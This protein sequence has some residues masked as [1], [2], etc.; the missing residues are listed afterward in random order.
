MAHFPICRRFKL[1]R[2]AP[3][4]DRFRDVCQPVDNSP[5]TLGAVAGT[6]KGVLPT[7]CK[8]ALHEDRELLRIGA[9]S[10]RRTEETTEID[11]STIT[12]PT[13]E[14]VDLKAQLVRQ[15]EFY[16]RANYVSF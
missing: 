6:R 3:V 2:L 14:R 7:E 4:R 10:F 12:M 11:S 9:L 16:R 8:I 13:I 1:R 15:S 5:D